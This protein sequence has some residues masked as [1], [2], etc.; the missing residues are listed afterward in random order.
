MEIGRA[1]PRVSLEL[2]DL[3]EQLYVGE[4]AGV[5][6]RVVNTGKLAV[7]GLQLVTSD[8]IMRLAD[9]EFDSQT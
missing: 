9:G 1:R 4:E 8:D 5:E 6:L 2:L 7:E 3:P